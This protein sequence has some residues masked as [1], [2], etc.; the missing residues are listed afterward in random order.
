MKTIGITNIKIGTRTKRATAIAAM[1]LGCFSAQS[2][3]NLDTLLVAVQANNLSLQAARKG[4][5]AQKADGRVGLLP[6]NP[7]VSVG[8][9]QGSP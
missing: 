7:H 3:V 5:D 9:M 2:Q 8:L 4:V 6:S 1:I